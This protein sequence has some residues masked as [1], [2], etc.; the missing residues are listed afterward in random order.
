MWATMMQFSI[1]KHSDYCAQDCV[2]S[3]LGLKQTIDLAAHFGPFS[4]D[5]WDLQ[6]PQ[7]YKKSKFLLLKAIAVHERSG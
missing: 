3:F 6:V 5:F 1:V 4:P 2:P 7:R